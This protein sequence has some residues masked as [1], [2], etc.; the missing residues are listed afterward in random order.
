MTTT[1]IDGT[2]TTSFSDEE[3][4]GEAFFATRGEAVEYAAEQE[5]NYV[6]RVFNLTD[7]DVAAAFVR[8]WEDADEA[9]RQMDEWSW[10]EDFVVRQPDT[11]AREE[12]HQF[13]KAWVA[14]HRL[15]VPTWRVDE[16]EGPFDWST[17]AEQSQGSNDAEPRQAQGGV[18]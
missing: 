18:S 17:E 7:D 8:D 14:R 6:G 13:V 11:K 1:P 12:L 9:I 16:I 10:R 3:W 5:H 15:R 4:G 2:W